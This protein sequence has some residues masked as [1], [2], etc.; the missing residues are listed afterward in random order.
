MFGLCITLQTLREDPDYVQH[1]SMEIQ[2][3]EQREKELQ[4]IITENYLR[5][6]VPTTC[7]RGKKL[8]EQVL[9]RI[10]LALKVWIEYYF[11]MIRNIWKLLYKTATERGK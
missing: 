11:V 1:H 7:F 6:I 10:S 5:Q 9:K 2:Q 4:S 8:K 3:I